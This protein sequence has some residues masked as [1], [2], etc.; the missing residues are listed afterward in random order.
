[1]VRDRHC[2]QCRDTHGTAIYTTWLVATQ[3]IAH[4]VNED[5]FNMLKMQVLFKLVC[6]EV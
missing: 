4:D 5:F 2:S 6:S 1:M 3:S